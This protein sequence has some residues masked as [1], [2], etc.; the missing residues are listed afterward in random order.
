[1]DTPE[2]SYNHKTKRDMEKSGK[3]LKA[4]IDQGKESSNFVKK[5][6]KK[7]MRSAWSSMS[8][9]SGHRGRVTPLVYWPMSIWPMAEC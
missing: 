3:D 5:L 1:M 8:R 7:V 6:V 9:R 4:I 2:V